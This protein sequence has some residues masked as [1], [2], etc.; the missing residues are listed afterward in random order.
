MFGQVTGVTPQSKEEL[1]TMLT[2]IGFSVEQKQIGI[3][4]GYSFDEN[5]YATTKGAECTGRLDAQHDAATFNMGSNWRLPTSNEYIELIMAIKTSETDTERS[6]AC[7][8]EYLN[9]QGVKQ[10]LTVY[11]DN[12][13]YYMNI[14]GLLDENDNPLYSKI[15][16]I[17][18]TNTNTGAYIYIPASGGAAGSIL[19]GIG[20]GAQYQSSSYMNSQYAG[21]FMF[22]SQYVGFNDLGIRYLGYSARVVQA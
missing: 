4:E 20:V 6:L 10:T 17:R 7:Q 2:Q 22:A 3:V 15:L 11:R 1:E 8:Y 18:I 9:L 5:S 13:G 16:G 19:S 21:Q 14:S 12:P